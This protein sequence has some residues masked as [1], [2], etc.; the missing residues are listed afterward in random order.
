MRKKHPKAS[1]VIT[2]KNIYA[3]I[4]LNGFVARHAFESRVPKEK[5]A[6]IVNHGSSEIWIATKPT[7]KEEKAKPKKKTKADPK[8]AAQDKRVEE[9]L[10]KVVFDKAK[11][12]SNK[13]I[14]KAMTDNWKRG[15]QAK[16]LKQNG[17]PLSDPLQ[18][19]FMIEIE[20]GNIDTASL[21]K[22]LKVDVKA[23]AKKCLTSSSKK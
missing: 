12:A 2:S 23:E 11:K 9:H 18:A 15:W 21:V 14:A 3:D 7:P 17:I 8:K 4:E 6:F 19:A 5:F 1:I 20:N 16:F 22:L 13:Q 10:E